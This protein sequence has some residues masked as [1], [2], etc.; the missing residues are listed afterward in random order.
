MTNL[1]KLVQVVNTVEMKDSL[2]R[3][4]TAMR[5]SSAS[6]TPKVTSL[7]NFKNTNIMVHAQQERCAQLKPLLQQTELLNTLAV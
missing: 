4:E 3:R 2:P 5:D 7:M 1:V 6:N